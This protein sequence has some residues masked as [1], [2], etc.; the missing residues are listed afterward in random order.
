M[1][2]E[3]ES[4][5]LDV[6]V[7]GVRDAIMDSGCP[8]Y[9]DGSCDLDCVMDGECVMDGGTCIDINISEL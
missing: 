9:G 7:F 1:K 4:P 3:Y 8:T 5:V 6:Y 2:Q